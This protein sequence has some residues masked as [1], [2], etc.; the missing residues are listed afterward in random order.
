M[1]PRKKFIITAVVISV[2]LVLAFTLYMSDFSLLSLKYSNPKLEGCE[3]PS[4][5]IEESRNV[6]AFI[7]QLHIDKDRIQ[8]DDSL[9]I[10]LGDCW[11][12]KSWLYPK[13]FKKIEFSTSSKMKYL[14]SIQTMCFTKSSEERFFCLRSD[15]YPDS[16]QTAF[17]LININPIIRHYVPAVADTF[18]CTFYELAKTSDGHREE[19][20]ICSVKLN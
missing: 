1:A 16:N 14:I 3:R 18:N 15:E 7:R 4:A 17:T 12:E 13:S 20:R 11:I 2:S 19:K 5:S 10:A 6:N 9:E 8:I